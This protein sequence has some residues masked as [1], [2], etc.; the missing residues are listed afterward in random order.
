M[1][2]TLTKHIAFLHWLTKLERSCLWKFILEARNLRHYE[3][4]QY[5]SVYDL[6]QY[7]SNGRGRGETVDDALPTLTTNSGKLFSK[8]VY[9]ICTIHDCLRLMYM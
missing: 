4:T 8:A 6:A 3:T 2:V 7:V 9:L 5:K 1:T